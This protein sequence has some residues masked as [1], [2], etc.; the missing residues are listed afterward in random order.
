VYEANSGNVAFLAESHWYTSR[1]TVRGTSALILPLD[2]ILYIAHGGAAHG[3][4]SN[5]TVDIPNFL[6]ETYFAYCSLPALLPCLIGEQTVRAIAHHDDARATEYS[7]GDEHQR[8]ALH[9]RTRTIETTTL[10]REDSERVIADQLGIHRA[11]A[12]DQTATV[13]AWRTA[14]DQLG[15]VLARTWP[16]VITVPRSLGPV[17]VA[18]RWSTSERRGAAAWIELSADARHAPVWTMERQ[19]GPIPN[20]T[21]IGGE[22]FL[23][24]GK[25]PLDLSSL[26]T[27]V[28]R[29]KLFSIDVRR[30]ISVHVARHV[31]DAGSIAQ[32]IDVIGSLCGPGAPYR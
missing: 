32:V 27:L 28:S 29:A 2:I 4:W 30:N 26:R 20:G 31:P 9:V 6:D 16:P 24:T 10:V 17:T 13:D 12:A 23:V 18:L 8:V 15:G 1:W 19:S 25:P 5:V 21:T 7:A 11:L 14:A 3:Y 22:D